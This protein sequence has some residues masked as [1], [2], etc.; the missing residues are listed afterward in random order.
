M[1]DNAL[2]PA[3]GL[4]IPN[5]APA[6][7]YYRPINTDGYAS[8]AAACA[9]VPEGVRIG[10]KV[11]ISG[12]GEHIWLAGNLTNTGLVPF[13]GTG[14]APY[15]LA[16]LYSD[17]ST[18][19]GLE[20]NYR[21]LNGQT[22]VHFTLAAPTQPEG[23]TYASVTSPNPT[24]LL[25][26]AY[27]T[28]SAQGVEFKHP[29]TNVWMAGTLVNG[30]Y[31]ITFT[32]IPAGTYTNLQARLAT[33]T[34]ITATYGGAVDVLAATLAAPVLSIGDVQTGLIQ[35]L[36]STVA[37]ASGYRLFRSTTAT[38]T[39]SELPGGVQADID[40]ED[41]PLTSSTTYFYKVQS[42][43]DGLLWADS[44]LSGYIS[45]TTLTPPSEVLTPPANPR[46]TAATPTTVTVAGDPVPNASNYQ[47][48][49]HNNDLTV[50]ML[51]G[52]YGTPSAT[53]TGLPT[54]TTTYYEWLT[55]GNGTTYLNSPRG[56]TFAARTTP[57]APTIIGIF[58][59]GLAII[60]AMQDEGNI[61]LQGTRINE[62]SSVTI[63][64][65][66]CAYR[67]D[68]HQY[69]TMNVPATARTGPL[70]ITGPGGT[71]TIP[72][73]L[74]WGPAVLHQINEDDPRFTY[75][76]SWPNITF[77]AGQ[78][79]GGDV[80]ASGEVF[81]GEVVAYSVTLTFS[82]ARDERLTLW[83]GVEYGAPFDLYDNGQHRFSY[84]GAPGQVGPPGAGESPQIVW[85][86]TEQPQLGGPVTVPYYFTP[87]QHIIR[88][89]RRSSMHNALPNGD[90]SNQ[91]HRVDKA[92]AVLRVVIP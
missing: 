35:V 63:N 20:R 4:K 71:A 56:V 42:V 87:G 89:V 75:E 64:G 36:G 66:P 90:P 9:A 30:Q 6:D 60:G 15:T 84:N 3:E 58:K 38:G 88:I 59:D 45:A 1:P 52:T 23:L 79:H 91:F 72:T 70:V 17:T 14:G 33:T 25:C 85:S 82:G 77:N 7:W 50:F 2:Q 81:D 26:V 22:T 76:G 78:F 5:P 74:I 37:N 61:V 67:I 11:L 80:R 24:T 44:V 62:V 48:W 34:N 41:T 43:G 27:P 65:L 29:I 83:G 10:R 28:S 8:L 57:P 39:Y 51:Y 31:R 18:G 68:S 73:F 19:P 86:S 49:K 13:G 40:Y 53:V 46:M 16:D 32:G 92:E 55:L 54:D 21:T 12:L 69:L 47:L